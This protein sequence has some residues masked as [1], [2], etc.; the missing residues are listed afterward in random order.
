MAGTKICGL[1]E[2]TP[3]ALRLA[4]GVSLSSCAMLV[5][6]AEL[7]EYPWTAGTSSLVRTL[8]T[9]AAANL[10]SLELRNMPLDA[11]SLRAL[12]RAITCRSGARPRELS[13]QYNGLRE[14]DVPALIALLDVSSFADP[15]LTPWSMVI[16]LPT[17]HGVWIGS[18][19]SLRTTYEAFSLPPKRLAFLTPYAEGRARS[20]VGNAV[21]RGASAHEYD[22]TIDGDK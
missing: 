15:F 4:D 9:P 3:A 1:A 11:H 12:T 14:A 17:H 10:A 13:L 20:K 18:A 22:H 21:R 2:L 8:T 6:D 5:A 19:S 16:E 7:A